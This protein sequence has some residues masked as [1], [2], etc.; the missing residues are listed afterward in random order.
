MKYAIFLASFL[1]IIQSTYSVSLNIV[2][3]AKASASS[4]VS[5]SLNANN[6]N[7][8]VIAIKGIGNWLTN[9]KKSWVKLT[10]NTHLWVNKVV[11]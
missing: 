6:I 1:C 11:I 10:W 9:E 2:D 5:E 3:K 4:S 7:D 8:N